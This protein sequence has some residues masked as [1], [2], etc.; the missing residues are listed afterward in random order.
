MA[1]C[2]KRATGKGCFFY[3]HQPWI[4]GEIIGSTA[5]IFIHS[6]FIHFLIAIYTIFYNRGTI[7]FNRK[8][9]YT[10]NTSTH[11]LEKQRL[12]QSINEDCL[13]TVSLPES[14][15]VSLQKRINQWS[16]YVMPLSETAKASL[17]IQGLCYGPKKKTTTAY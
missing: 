7:R 15:L 10:V 14:V 4:Y 2:N 5:A 9:S 17:K 16:I 13:E 6:F 3:K 1:Q 12:S 8:K 11:S